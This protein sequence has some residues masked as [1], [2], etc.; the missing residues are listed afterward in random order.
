M[1]Q[2]SREGLICATVQ[3]GLQCA[4][5]L[6]SIRTYPIPVRPAGSLAPEAIA[7]LEYCRRYHTGVNRQVKNL[8]VNVHVREE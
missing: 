7:I 4:L 6:G 5:S 2:F 8:D 3:D 1:S